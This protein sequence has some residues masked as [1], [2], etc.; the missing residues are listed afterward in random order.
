MWSLAVCV[1]IMCWH[2]RKSKIAIIFKIAMS[3]KFHTHKFVKLRYNYMSV[4]VALYYHITY[5]SYQMFRP[6][7]TGPLQWQNTYIFKEHMDIAGE[8]EKKR[9]ERRKDRHACMS[10]L[11]PLMAMRDE[12]TGSAA[13]C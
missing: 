1:L 13:D 6:L 12:S 4:Y 7:C 5:P 8:N 3:Q 9:E 10:L 11:Q 2:D